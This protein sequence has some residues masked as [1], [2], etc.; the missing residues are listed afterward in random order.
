MNTVLTSGKSMNVGVFAA[1]CASG[2]ATTSGAQQVNVTPN[3]ILDLTTVFDCEG[4]DFEVSW[5]GE[6]HLT[7]TIVIGSS[8]TV[9]IFGDETSSVGS[10]SS[11]SSQEALEELTSTLAL[12][13]GLTSAVVGVAPTNITADTDASI[14]FGPM[15]YVNGG[16]LILEGLIV[17]G[18]FAVAN[19]TS[20][21]NGIRSVYGSGGGV[22]AV[23]ST[24]LVS[25]CDFSDNFAEHFGGGIFANQSTV[26][27]VDTSFGNCEAG[28]VSTVDEEDLEGEGGAIYVSTFKTHATV[29]GVFDCPANEVHSSPKIACFEEMSKGNSIDSFRHSMHRTNNHAKH[30][31]RLEKYFEVLV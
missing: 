1:P 18:G 9:R 22:Y 28:F 30:M 7:G 4:G 11:L 15:F 6:V 13:F 25:R 12:P 16:E 20:A 3:T 29:V 2:S 31:W 5:S 19:T 27:V 24:V 17:R 14:S 10:S 21:L 23:D 8:T 26:Q